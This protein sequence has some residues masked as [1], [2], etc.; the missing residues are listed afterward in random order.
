MPSVTS[1]VVGVAQLVDQLVGVAHAVA[2]DDVMT[3]PALSPAFSAGESVVTLDTSTPPSLT[4]KYSA[5]C[6]D[7][8]STCTPRRRAR[9]HAAACRSRS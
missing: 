9:S 7:S 2:V 8:V 1:P 5:S 4:P 3:S 6:G